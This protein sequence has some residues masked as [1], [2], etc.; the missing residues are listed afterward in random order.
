MTLS[1]R[2]STQDP[3]RSARVIPLRAGPVPLHRPATVAVSP[4]P[5]DRTFEQ[6]SLKSWVLALVLRLLSLL[7]WRSEQCPRN[8]S[9]IRRVTYLPS[10][11]NLS[12]FQAVVPLFRS[13][14]W[15]SRLL[16]RKVKRPIHQSEHQLA[17][18]IGLSDK[19]A[20]DMT[21][22]KQIAAL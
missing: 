5:K 16:I 11:Q 19:A 14:A 13:Q 7:F 18:I 15:R 22:G 9:T 8:A 17:H 4:S 10:A 3:T 1:S 21:A 2:P 6:S 12:S 20:A